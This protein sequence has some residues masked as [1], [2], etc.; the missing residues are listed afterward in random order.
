MK[1][2]ILVTI[3]FALLLIIT[4]T[5][6]ADRTF[7]CGSNL[8]HVGD[9]I[10]RV[11]TLCGAP[12]FTHNPSVVSTREMWVYDCGPGRLVKVLVFNNGRL[13]NVRTE[14]YGSRRGMPCSDQSE[15]T[16]RQ[17]KVR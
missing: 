17:R 13:I 3:A 6:H 11:A 9:T 12:D 1:G 4:T 10:Y 15:W 2:I 8:V 14:R 7:R 16:R 5:A